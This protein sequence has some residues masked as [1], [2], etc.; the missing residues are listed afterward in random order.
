MTEVDEVYDIIRSRLFG[1]YCF[2][3]DG[4]KDIKN[5]Y[6]HL[7]VLNPSK[8]ANNIKAKYDKLTKKSCFIYITKEK[9]IFPF[10]GNTEKFYPIPCCIS[11][12]KNE[13]TS[14]SFNL[15]TDKNMILN[16]LENL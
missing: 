3:N 2:N 6:H 14:I 15:L 9:K 12:R 1:Y 11:F 10:T 8:Q 13:G 5:V 7:V 16:Y 4:N